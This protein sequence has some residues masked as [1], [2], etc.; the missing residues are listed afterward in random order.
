MH[1]AEIFLFKTAT[2]LDSQLSRQRGD[3]LLPICSSFISQD[4]LLD[5]FANLPVEG[6]KTDVDSCRRLPASFFDQAPDL[7]Q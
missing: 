7:D 1:S 4:F 6:G 2:K 5:S 3:N